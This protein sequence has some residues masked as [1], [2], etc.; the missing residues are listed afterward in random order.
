MAVVEDFV[1]L[2]VSGRAGGISERGGS[3]GAGGRAGRL[4]DLSRIGGEAIDG[5]VVIEPLIQPA[6]RVPL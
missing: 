5:V 4:D 3:T 1:G 2:N 6:H